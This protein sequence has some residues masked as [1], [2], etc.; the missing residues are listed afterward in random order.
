MHPYLPH[1][2]SDIAAAHRTEIPAEDKPPLS[3]EEEMEE[4]E[5]WVEGNGPDHS[6]GYY[7][8][9]EAFNFPPPEQFTEDEIKEVLKAFGKMMFT[10]NHG[11][12]L[13]ELLPLPMAYNL[14]VDTLN[15]KTD[16]VNSG[17]MTF[18]FCTGYAPDCMLKEYCPCLEYWNEDINDDMGD[19]DL[20]SN[21]LPF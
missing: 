4:I 19:I 9:L 6:F 21:E 12:S 18:D 14:T 15:T 8:G 13:P 7:C 10:W 11:I 17:M 3:F 1:L 20:S 16:I 5:N 2:L